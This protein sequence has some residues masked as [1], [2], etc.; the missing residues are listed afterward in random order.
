MTNMT[1]MYAP[2]AAS[3]SIHNHSA[4]LNKEFQDSPAEVFKLPSPLIFTPQFSV[5]KVSCGVSV[6][7]FLTTNGQVF[8]WILGCGSVN[9][10]LDC[11]QLLSA[12]IEHLIVDIACGNHH[13]CCLCE[14]GAILTTGCF[15]YGQLG[16]YPANLTNEFSNEGCYTNQECTCDK[17]NL[18][19][20]QNNLKDVFFLTFKSRVVKIACGPKQ[21]VVVTED[22]D[23]WGMGQGVCGWEYQNVKTSGKTPSTLIYTIPQ[24]IELSL[25]KRSIKIAEVICGN[26]FFLAITQSGGVISW[27]CNKLGQLGHGVV[28][29]YG[30]PH[31]VLFRKE[32][33]ISN[34]FIVED[35]FENSSNAS[36]SDGIVTYIYSYDSCIAKTSEGSLWFW[37]LFGW[38]RP[39]CVN[40]ISSFKD[41]IGLSTALYA[42]LLFRE[43]IWLDTEGRLLITNLELPLKTQTVYA[44][45][46]KPF[47]TLSASSKLIIAM[48]SSPCQQVICEEFNQNFE[49]SE[50]NLKS[51]SE[52]PLLTFRDLSRKDASSTNETMSSTYC[53][54]HAFEQSEFPSTVFPQ[55]KHD[56]QEIP[57]QYCAD[58]NIIIQN[59]QIKLN[60]LEA[61]F[62][63][64]LSQYQRDLQVVS[65]T[66]NKK[67][68]QKEIFE[69]RL[70]DILQEGPKE[71]IDLW[72]EKIRSGIDDSI[73]KDPDVLQGYTPMLILINRFVQKFK[74]LENQKLLYMEQNN[75]SES[76]IIDYAQK[77][78]ATLEKL[79][80]KEK[81]FLSLQETNT[82]L[83]MENQT[84]SQKISSLEQRISLLNDSKNEESETICQLNVSLDTLTNQLKSEQRK[85][86][87]MSL[88]IHRLTSK[89]EKKTINITKYETAITSSKNIQT[90]L[91]DLESEYFELKN[92]FLQSEEEK[93]QLHLKISAKDY[94][95]EI[96][97]TEKEDFSEQIER[98]KLS[99][100]TIEEKH[101][102]LQEV[103]SEET[104]KV[105]MERRQFKNEYTTLIEQLATTRKLLEKAE[106]A[107]KES[108]D[109]KDQKTRELMA[110]I[111]EIQI[112]KSTLEENLKSEEKQFVK[113]IKVLKTKNLQLSKEL[114]TEKLRK[115]EEEM[116]LEERNNFFSREIKQLK[117]T[118]DETTKSY[119]T[120]VETLMQLGCVELE[121]L[122]GSKQSDL[123]SRILNE[124]LPWFFENPKQIANSCA[125]KI[126]Q[127]ECRLHEKNNL[128]ENLEVTMRS[129]E[130][131]YKLKLE[132]LP[133]S[134]DTCEFLQSQ[135]DALE[136]EVL[137]KQLFVDKMDV[138]QQLT[139]VHCLSDTKEDLSFTRTHLT[140]QPSHIQKNPS[141]KHPCSVTVHTGIDFAHSASIAN[142][143]KTLRDDPS[144]I[145]I[146]NHPERAMNPLYNN[147]LSFKDKYESIKTDEHNINS[148]SPYTLSKQL[149]CSHDRV[150]PHVILTRLTPSLEEEPF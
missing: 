30:L 101:T 45:N 87:M 72:A 149:A 66:L 29:S 16:T 65:E 6:A 59:I 99:L 83:T 38:T 47:T 86:Q 89:L 32:H 4:L 64:T 133:E 35:Q 63:D 115:K 73:S 127:M 8:T 14:T 61:E 98:L 79:L 81:E 78:D 132:S 120:L 109:Q 111:E 74:Y 3:L 68:E 60:R 67:K 23:V 20:V 11:P 131:N 143:H 70:L 150:N 114:N 1:D 147:M 100:E 76:S 121:S 95:N 93:N 112:Q 69:K 58:K 91:T 77:F 55:H 117:T 15:H 125:D 97:K 9:K 37:G 104:E 13:I 145:Y 103:L 21:T 33:N 126:K 62:N 90:K 40:D 108:Q 36:S 84:L 2:S 56:A 105:E 141:E 88:K 94:D 22:G 92:K 52:N 116:Y 113:D 102:R 57:C 31:P 44:N 136:K 43:V 138:T 10:K 12:S 71:N 119:K 137:E 27:G 140:T 146:R 17:V 134:C 148:T 42:S 49:V 82:N 46:E 50:D 24:K 110:I 139:N 85:N 122:K 130:N 107:L 48:S 7:A 19:I 25:G 28:C 75:T 96:L 128:I 106:K 144:C 53:T 142:T 41:C 135:V 54:D 80:K 26:N 118:I 5:N 124:S 34:D 51:I 18:Q 123:T 39:I 129:M